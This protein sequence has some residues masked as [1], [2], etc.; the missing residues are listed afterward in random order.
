LR[1]LPAFSSA[2]A[3]LNFLDR[4]REFGK[5][6]FIAPIH[7]HARFLLNCGHCRREARDV[8]RLGAAGLGKMTR[9]Y[10]L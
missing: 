6:E 2:N 8:V 1:L 10:W 5:G 3:L 9:S 7:A 4:I